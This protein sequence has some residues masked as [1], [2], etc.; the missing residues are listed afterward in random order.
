MPFIT[1]DV[2]LDEFS[3]NELKRELESRG[4]T[5]IE[6]GE[7]TPMPDNLSRVQHLADCGLIADARTEALTLVSK[8]I[9]RSL[10]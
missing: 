7:S 9:G 8:A 6:D 4:F 10:Q 5:V 2:D 3:D 1:V